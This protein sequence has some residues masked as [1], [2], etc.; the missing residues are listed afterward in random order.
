MLCPRC[1]QSLE[2]GHYEGVDVHM[3]LECS[4]LL[5]SQRRLIPLMNQLTQ[6]LAQQVDLDQ[7]VPPVPDQ[8][9]RV[10]CPKC[11]EQMVNF[12][13][14]GTNIIRL[15][16]CSSGGLIWIDPTELSAMAVLFARTKKLTDAR[17][18][19]YEY[20]LDGLA[21]RVDKLLIMRALSNGFAMG[22]V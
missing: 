13:Y 6:Q 4:G 9:G 22:G 3:C 2:A 18:K 16:R 7:P 20:E 11:S 15:D 10:K 17:Q 1:Q 19:F 21:R 12:G 8:P 5:V 14:M